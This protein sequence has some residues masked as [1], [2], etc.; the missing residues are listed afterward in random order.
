MGNREALLKGALECLMDKGYAGTTA[1]DIAGRAGTSLA[2]IGY[3]FGSTDQLLHEAIA[4]GFRLWRDKTAAVLGANA[5]RTPEEV[6]GAVG[7][8][9]AKLFEEQRPLLIVFMEALSLSDRAPEVQSHAAALYR[10]ERQGIAA[11]LAAARGEVHDDDE[12][13]ASVLQAVVDGLIVQSLVGR[14][15]ASSPRDVLTTLAPLI[16]GTRTIEEGDV[17]V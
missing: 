12:V 16:L 6:L 1:R 17:R 2:A 15:E 9:L 5:G 8:E 3:H 7:D 14:T 11:L 10:E 13:L 4:D